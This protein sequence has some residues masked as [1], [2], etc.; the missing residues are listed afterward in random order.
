MR[1]LPALD[2]PEE[3]AR[4]RLGWEAVGTGAFAAMLPNKRVSRYR[5]PR[6]ERDGVHR[7]LV[8]PCFLSTDTPQTRG[9][10]SLAA[11]SSFKVAVPGLAIPLPPRGTQALDEPQLNHQWKQ[12]KCAIKSEDSHQNAFLLYQKWDPQGR[13]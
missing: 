1:I 10:H 9:M 2:V 12:S 13:G 8:A 5:A 7:P 3:K 4:G 11:E 6:L